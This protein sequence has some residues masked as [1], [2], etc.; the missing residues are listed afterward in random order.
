MNERPAPS[1]MPA[2]P[3]QAEGPVAAARGPAAPE[4]E[5]PADVAWLFRRTLA[6]GRIHPLLPLV[7]RYRRERP[8]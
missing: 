5:L 2:W 3:A 4:A 1:P 7:L 8:P 6:A